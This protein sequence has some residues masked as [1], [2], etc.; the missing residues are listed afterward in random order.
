MKKKL[1]VSFR[2]DVRDLA[3]ILAWALR[4]GVIDQYDAS[5]SQLVGLALEPVLSALRN[6]ELAHRHPADAWERLKVFGL[7]ERQASKKRPEYALDESLEKIIKERLLDK[8]ERELDIA[9]MC[10]V[11]YGR[12]EREE[13]KA[14]KTGDEQK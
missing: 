1:V 10:N 2:M 14:D 5:V 4:N 11:N 9:A 12:S 6:D 7:A 8:R 13:E 3:N